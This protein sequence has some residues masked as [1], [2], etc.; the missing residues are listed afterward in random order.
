MI[1]HKPKSAEE[2]DKEW[3]DIVNQICEREGL[4]S[5]SDA[6]HVASIK[7][8]NDIRLDAFKAGMREAAE[9]AD[10]S[11][12]CCGEGEK[13]SKMILTTADELREI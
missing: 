10:K 2:W 1:T 6:I 12:A 9:L 5:D 8:Y 7:H 3:S 11:E 4:R 13:I